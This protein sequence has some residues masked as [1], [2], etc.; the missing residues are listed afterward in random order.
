VPGDFTVGA[1]LIVD[2]SSPLPIKL[3]VDEPLTVGADRLI[4]T[5]PR[6]AST[7]G[8]RS[9]STSARR[10][11]S[12][13]YVGWRLLGGVIAGCDDVGRGRS[14]DGRQRSCGDRADDRSVIGRRTE[15]CIRAGVMFGA[16]DSIDGIVARIKAEWPRPSVPTVIATG[17]MAEM[18]SSLC[19]TFDRVEPYLTLQGLAIAYGLLTRSDRIV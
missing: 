4:N 12:V 15:D 19:K 2:A 3:D 13:A 14:R 11:R 10:R 8:M 5:S 9:S 1:P 18:M 17:G 6:V 7:A 16:A